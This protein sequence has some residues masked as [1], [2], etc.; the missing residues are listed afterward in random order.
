[1]RSWMGAIAAAA[2][3]AV[4]PSAAHADDGSSLVQFKLPDK[5]TVD[6]I[7]AQGADL[8]H[9]VIPVEGGVLV[10]VQVTPEERARLEAQGYPAVAVISDAG[11]ADRLRAQ[12]NETLEA[13]ADAKAALQRSPAKGKNAAGGTVRAQRADYF[14]NYAGRYISIEATTSEAAIATNRYKRPA[15]DRRVAGRIRRTAG[16]GEPLGAAGP[17]RHPGAVPLPRERL[18]RGQSQRRRHDARDRQDRGA[19]R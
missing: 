9:G 12:R 6:Q 15:A 13:E 8:D 7:A 17:G 14:E 1:M 5:A 18:P 4:L 11:N 3:I 2:A 19:Q 10:S 16:L